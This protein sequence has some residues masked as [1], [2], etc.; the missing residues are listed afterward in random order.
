MGVESHGSTDKVRRIT[1]GRFLWRC[2][3]FEGML[4]LGLAALALI[5]LAVDYPGMRRFKRYCDY[6]TAEALKAAEP[7]VVQ[8]ELTF[9]KDGQTY[10]ML[11]VGF[12]RFVPSGAAFLVYDADGRLVD[13]T[14]DSGDN[15]RFR[16]A[17]L[18]PWRKACSDRTRRWL[19]ETHLP[20]VHLAA[21][22]TMAEFVS[23]MNEAAKDFDRPEKPKAERGVRFWCCSE[24]ASIVFPPRETSEEPCKGACGLSGNAVSFWTVLTNACQQTGCRFVV[25]ATEVGILGC[26]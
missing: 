24:T 18:K 10:T 16:D 4:L 3:C 13:R 9:E 8:K 25:N 22:T 23:F 5:V 11:D 19:Q 14:A 2:I 26:Q 15:P 1:V 12:C 20:E 21:P 6:P 7:D 17:W